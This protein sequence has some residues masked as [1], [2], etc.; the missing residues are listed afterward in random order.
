MSDIALIS[1]FAGVGGFDLAA[2]NLDIP[3]IAAVEID[4]NAR[5]VLAHQFPET[6]LYTD[7]T[8][9]TGKE[10]LGDYE[11][12]VIVTGGFPC[13]DLSI[14]GKRAGLVGERSGLFWEII[15]IAEE[16]KPQALLLE[17]V[18]GLL[19]SNGGRD[20][21]TVIGALGQLGYRVGWRV[22]DAQHF[23]VPQRRR[24]VFIVAGHFGADT[25]AEVLLEC[26]SGA[27]DFASSNQTG[28]DATGTVTG[29]VGAG[30]TVV[31]ERERERESLR[32]GRIRDL[33]SRSQN[34]Q[35]IYGQTTRR[36]GGHR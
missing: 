27:G 2:Q 3:T 35:R 14:A 4:D 25:L 33:R 19:S 17:N 12:T 29:G 34:S 26:E 7:V 23:G 21:G 6:R 28:Q 22:L 8:K 9:V 10:L 5:G 20:M 32:A 24:R 13:Q 31:R 30:R 18:P 36:H 15:R 1:L 11:G 16:I